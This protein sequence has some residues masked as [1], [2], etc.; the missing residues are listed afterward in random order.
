MIEQQAHSILINISTSRYLT[1]FDGKRW[2]SKI[3]TRATNANLMLAVRGL[4]EE[5]SVIPKIF[6]P[7][8]L[9]RCSL[10]SIS[11]SD[12]IGRTRFFNWLLRERAPCQVNDRRGQ[13][14]T[15]N[16]SLVA[17]TWCENG[18]FNETE[19]HL[20]FDIDDSLPLSFR[21]P[22][23]VH[24]RYTYNGEW[25]MQICRA[26]LP[27]QRRSFDFFVFLFF[28]SLLLVDAPRRRSVN[29][30]TSIELRSKKRKYEA[31]KRFG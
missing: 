6:R 21:R 9:G 3:L 23:S 31:F 7:F 4:N 27:S 18:G 29:A 25:F 14:I 1:I 22:Q 10:Q 12:G 26:N 2:K 13:H 15:I 11:Q 17:L 28:F 30:C 19:F 8:I 24:S 20:C 5:S 16:K